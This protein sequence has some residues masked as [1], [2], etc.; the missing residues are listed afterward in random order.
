MFGDTIGIWRFN[1]E[2]NKLE[3]LYSFSNQIGRQP[4][5]V[6]FDD[7]QTTGIVASTD[8][9]LWINIPSKEE[10]DVDET[11]FL[12]DIKNIL[13]RNKKF[14]VLANKFM[15]KLGYFLLELDLMLDKMKKPRYVI[16]WENK[17]E[18]DDASLN[19]FQY[20]E[21]DVESETL[22]VS[23]KSIHI[24]LYTVLLINVKTSRIIFKHDN[25]QLWESEVI[26]FL[27]TYQNDFIILNKEGTSFIPLAST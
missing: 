23:Y 19:F 22:V 27:N 11:F 1:F 18:I 14:Y 10:I 20:D 17:L 24:N 5:F 3:S 12:G 25:Y 8:D 26:G 16:K 15:R 6:V 2:K 13:Y 21:N 9:V 7:S 4:D